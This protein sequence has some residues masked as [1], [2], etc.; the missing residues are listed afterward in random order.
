MTGRIFLALVTFGVWGDA[1]TTRA[2]WA[3]KGVPLSQHVP[4]SPEAIEP[5]MNQ[6][7]LAFLQ[8]WIRTPWAKIPAC[9]QGGAERRLAP[10][11]RVPMADSTGFELPDR[12]QDMVP[13]AG[14]SA[15][16]AGAQIPLVGAYN[17]RGF[18][19][20][21]LM[22]WNVPDQKDSDTVVALAQPHD[23]FLFD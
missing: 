1:K 9:Q 16:P 17:P 18:T 22:P 21:A 2:S 12:R 3:A 15:A 4:V 14:G 7:A 11:A 10:F 19:P 5:R 23:L 6:R 13:G 20:L 8:A